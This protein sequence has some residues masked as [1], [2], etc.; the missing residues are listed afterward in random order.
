MTEITDEITRLTLAR[1]EKKNALN[2]ELRE[3][4]AS[5]TRE[6]DRDGT[7]VLVFDGAGDTFCS[8]A[9]L[10]EAEDVQLTQ[11]MTR[12]IREFNGIV[13]GQIRNYAVGGGFALT[14]SFDLRYAS[15]GTAF[16]LP[17]T[18]IGG[19]TMN[20]TAKLLPLI[21]GDGIARELALTGREL[22][23]Q[24]A[25]EMGL[26]SG[27]CDP[28]ALEETV[29]SVAHEIMETKSTASIRLIKQTFNE[30]YPIE[31]VLEQERLRTFEREHLARE[32]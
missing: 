24:E 18:E 12:A 2:N 20:A 22:D 15:T 11:D 4:I 25:H 7:K 16:F 32:K 14:L 23:A 19:L 29:S 30:S 5:A 31:R 28:E 1:P 6:A 3:R 13:I 17:E 21:V 26:V 8:G 10:D 9:D 27:V